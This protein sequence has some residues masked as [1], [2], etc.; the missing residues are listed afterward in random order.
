[1]ADLLVRAD[2]T[3]VACARQCDLRSGVGQCGVRRLDDG[4]LI[5]DDAVTHIAVQPVERKPFYHYRPGVQLLTLGS[6]GCGTRCG[7]CRNAEAA[8]ARRWPR[9]RSVALSDPVGLAIERGAAGI[10]FSYNEPLI[11]AEQ[12]A[13]TCSAAV[14]QDLE[15]VIVTSG[16]ATPEALALLAPVTTAWRV[17]IKAASEQSALR[18]FG[19]AGLPWASA[20][21]ALRRLARTDRHLEV[22]V[23]YSPSI[24]DHNELALIGE[25]VC[26]AAG[27]DTAVHLQPLLPAHR[28]RAI[29]TP[30][31]TDLL[32]A[33]HLLRAAGL[34][35]VYVHFLG[36]AA[37]RAT[38]CECGACLVERSVVKVRVNIEP[39]GRCGSCGAPTPVKVSRQMQEAAA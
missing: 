15:A 7:Y 24:H 4:Q 30:T 16:W 18:I 20:F 6:W 33:R 19:E 17:D 23:T 39:D 22:S 35:H 8:L 34:R 25:R 2:G 27:H 28:L 12:V 3:C 26:A 36:P 5:V 38:W 1:M 31:L 32:T 13:E 29:E 21:E 37:L 11:R 14:K 9:A 10:A